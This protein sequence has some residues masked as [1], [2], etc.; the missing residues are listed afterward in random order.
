MSILSAIFYG[1]IQGLTEFLPISSSGHLA[2]VQNI[3]GGKNVEADYFSFSILLHL[4]TLAT[5][6]VVYYKDI[7]PMIPAFFRIVGKIFKG[8]FRFSECN[9]QEK[10]VICLIIATLPLAAALF[11]NDYVEVVSSNVKL[12]G[13]ILIFNGIVLFI[14]DLISK[15]KKGLDEMKPKNAVVVGLC[16]LFAIFPGLSRSGSTITG[17]RL[18]GFTREFAVKFSFILSV[19]AILGAN[20]LEIPSLVKN[21]V[22]SADIPAYILGM[23]AAALTGFAAMKL[24]S[25]IS[26][27]SNF[28]IFSY[29]SVI[30]GILAVIFG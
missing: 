9:S 8:K 13:G 29:Y 15:G 12:V 10:M 26:K 11:I 30:V 27:K 28:R 3:F 14:S 19:P 18:C 17:A 25:Y 16:Q 1:I 5:V 2:I 21:P 23:A 6:L 7:F 20:I 22:P 24:L 4:A